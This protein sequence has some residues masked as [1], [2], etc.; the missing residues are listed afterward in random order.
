MQK[1]K[2]ISYTPDAPFSVTSPYIQ[3]S[4]H[5]PSN[6]KSENEASIDYSTSCPVFQERGECRHGLRCRF[7]DN[8]V[9]YTTNEGIAL[10]EDAEKVAQRKLETTELNSIDLDVLKQIRSKKVCICCHISHIAHF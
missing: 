6:E 3:L 8:H 1:P 4:M 10:V 2:D 7:L 9:R 5:S